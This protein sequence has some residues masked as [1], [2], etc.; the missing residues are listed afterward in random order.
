M[1]NK[2][3]TSKKKQEA[4]SFRGKKEEK[5]TSDKTPPYSTH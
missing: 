4:K 5:L 3:F 2:W 1:I